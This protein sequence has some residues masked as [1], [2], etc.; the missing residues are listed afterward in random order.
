MQTKMK[1]VNPYVRIRE[2]ER[3][4]EILEVDEKHFKKYP[5]SK[6]QWKKIKE[7]EE[8]DS[9]I[10]FFVMEKLIIQ[11][12]IKYFEKEERVRGLKEKGESEGRE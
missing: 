11:D 12:C 7:K 8:V 6:K 3:E 2:L 5:P 10:F 9:K 4:L 1:I